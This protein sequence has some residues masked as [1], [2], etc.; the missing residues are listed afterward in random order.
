MDDTRWKDVGIK[1]RNICDPN[2]YILVCGS[3]EKFYDY[4]GIQGLDRFHKDLITNLRQ[5]TD[6]T[7]IFRGKYSYEAAHGT[8]SA[9]G[10]HVRA[11]PKKGIKF[12][13]QGARCLVT[14]ASNSACDGIFAGIPVITL[15]PHFSKHVAQRNLADVL[16]P[17]ILDTAAREK[18]AW[19]LAWEQWTLEDM[20]SGLVWEHLLPRILDG[21]QGNTWWD[22]KDNKLG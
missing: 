2:G 19:K 4:F 8:D 9:Y 3:S 1:F 16:N 15:G 18:W 5:M 10:A 21:P 22:I 14:F 13:L 7:I 12:S 17:R 11:D 6:A 20:S